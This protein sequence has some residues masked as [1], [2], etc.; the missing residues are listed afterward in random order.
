MNTFISSQIFR[1]LP[2][3]EPTEMIETKMFSFA[4]FMNQFHVI[5]GLNIRENKTEIN[6]KLDM[7]LHTDKNRCQ[8]EQDVWRQP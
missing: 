4:R 7:Y 1:S 6:W 5:V 2:Q 8:N 3:R